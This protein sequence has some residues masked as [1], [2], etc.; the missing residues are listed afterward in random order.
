MKLG[1][2]LNI[3]YLRLSITDW[4]NLNCMY[5]TPLEKEKFLPHDEVLRYEEMARLVK[6]FVSAGVRK[7][8][9]T[10]GEPL[11]KR[12]L[13]SLIKMLKEIKG[14]EDLVFLEENNFSL[15]KGDSKNIE[16]VF[17]DEKLKYLPGVYVL[18]L[19]VKTDK[20]KEI[21]VILEIQSKEILFAANLEVS[22]EYKEISPGDELSVSIKLFNLNDTKSH[23]VETS[24]FVKNID[25]ENIVSEN[26]K[27]IIGTEI[28]T[29]KSIVLPKNIKKGSYVFAVV[30]KFG[31]SISTSSYLFS[32]G[33]KSIFSNVDSM[34]L[35]FSIAVLA[36]LFGIVFLVFYLLK[37]RDKVQA[38]SLG[39]KEYVGVCS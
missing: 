38:Q 24:Y 9:I 12:D 30:S 11:I 32:I 26:E 25:N 28:I 19:T 3:D 8:R 37:E 17:K 5:C 36:F 29:T 33:K 23:E 14:L 39:L 21:P 2:N 34:T 22:S 20:E 16:I 31:N 7:V 18:P 10:G 15:M 4:C 35:V 13:I 6:I 27:I 1:K